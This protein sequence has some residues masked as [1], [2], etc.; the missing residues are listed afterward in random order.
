MTFS[1]YPLLL[2]CSD[3][4][5]FTEFVDKRDS[6]VA[7]EECGKNHSI[8]S[9]YVADPEKEYERTDNGTLIGLPP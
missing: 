4:C 6:V 2:D 5:K 9:L 3:C 7:C 8:A 1:D